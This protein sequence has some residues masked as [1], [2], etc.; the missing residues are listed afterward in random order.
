MDNES[1][2]DRFL[3]HRAV[4]GLGLYGKRVQIMQAVMGTLMGL[5]GIGALLAPA[6][7]ASPDIVNAAPGFLFGGAVMMAISRIMKY[8]L[9]PL[10]STS[11]WSLTPEARGLL[12]KLVQQRLSWSNFGFSPISGR[13]GRFM[14]R[15]IAWASGDSSFGFFG[16]SS[17]KVTPE[18]LDLLE[19]AAE[20]F[21]RSQG[22]L[23]SPSG[24]SLSKVSASAS[25]AADE[26]MAAIFDN[27][28]TMDRFP[29][30]A[31]ATKQ[32]IVKQIGALK[33]LADRL[34]D[35]A[36]RQETI[37]DKLTSSAT[38]D[39][40]LDEL[41]LEQLARA[42]LQSSESPGQSSVNA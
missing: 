24:S 30:S 31:A 42:E 5:L 35:L 13:R 3:K 8:R 19:S 17:A 23:Q 14:A 27:A 20:Q 29:E 7:G 25:K 18:V 1:S 32:Q 6:L 22:I 21:N 11:N 2:L 9:Q 33:E 10:M 28:A 37:S 38:M 16:H 34:E 4:A 12:L 40:V 36:T 15:R 41:R 39:S 26:S